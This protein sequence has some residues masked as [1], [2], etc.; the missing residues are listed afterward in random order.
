MHMFWC[1]IE[2]SVSAYGLVTRTIYAIRNKL[3]IVHH[4]RLLQI[5]SLIFDR[6]T[7]LQSDN[8][9]IQS[10]QK[11]KCVLHKLC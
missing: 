1:G 6:M 2:S 8:Y 5:I 9:S 11:V 4:L 3:F 10:I 7:K